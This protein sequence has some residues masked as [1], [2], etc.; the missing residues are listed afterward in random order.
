MS[1]I[2]V[3]MIPVD[4]LVPNEW[5]PNKQTAQ[6]YAQTV[7]EVRHTGQVAKPILVRRLGRSR[8]RYEISDGEHNWRTAKDCG[9]AEV[10]CVVRKMSDLEAMRQTFKRNQHGT[11]NPVLEG[12]MF[13]AM[14]EESGLS[15]VEFSK[16][17]DVS[18]GKVRNAILYADASD[19]RSE[20][21]TRNPER[22]AAEVGSEVLDGYLP[23]KDSILASIPIRTLRALKSYECPVELWYLYVEKVFKCDEDF[24]WFADDALGY[25]RGNDLWKFY[26]EAGQYSAKTINEFVEVTG[27]GTGLEEVEGYQE[28]INRLIRQESFNSRWLVGPFLERG[29]TFEGD[30]ES[31]FRMLVS[32]DQY[33]DAI[34]KFAGQTDSAEKFAGLLSHWV[35]LERKNQGLR[36]EDQSHPITIAV[37]D[38]AKKYPKCIGEAP[39]SVHER[40]FLMDIFDAPTVRRSRQGDGR[41][42]S[43]GDDPYQDRAGILTKRHSRRRDERPD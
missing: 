21:A 33:F 41:R 39:V 3:Q 15:N 36:Q 38:R 37:A 23:G 27:I 1:E 20:Y 10:P 22:Y 31:G 7:A 12:R 18:E 8:N 6:E 14:R 9:H 34:V 19:I 17:I 32:C 25:C 43:P 42:A 4:Q 29:L 40:S 28:L 35:D 16:S 30:P 2:I 5:N 13:R 26:D 11:H 24:P